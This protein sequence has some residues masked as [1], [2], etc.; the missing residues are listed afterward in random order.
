VALAYDAVSR[1]FVLADE[2]T[3]TL[4]IVDELTGNVVNLVSKGW[5]GTYRTSALAID[6]RRGDLW[7][8][9]VDPPG[10]DGFSRSAVHQL[11]LVS[12]RL[13]QTIRMPP[14]AGASRLVALAVG[15]TTVF[16]L[17]ALGRRIVSLSAGAK[18][19]RV[20][21]SIDDVESA[22][23]LTAASDTI[24]YVAH[25]A[26]IARVDLQ[27]RAITSVAG[28]SV[29]LTDLQSIAWH[30]G[31]LFGV[32][33]QSDGGHRAVR[34]ALD[35][36]GTAA[37]SAE[38]IEAAAAPAAS[39]SNGAFYYLASASGTGMTG[40]KA[41]AAATPLTCEHVHVRCGFVSLRRTHS[42]A[43]ARAAPTAPSSTGPDCRV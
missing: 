28:A 5:A 41:L 11:Q 29:D 43:R 7:T 1:R 25:P 19:L 42:A 20:Q 37:T 31:T 3:A 17:D 15:R 4:K 18:A 6:G 36:S 40:G 38:V 33:R 16:A 32:Q 39:L 13:L 10:K 9:G 30:D 21:M 35:R 14:E 26:G 8:I 12:G 2:S 34:I 22:S 24:V 23:S 27:A